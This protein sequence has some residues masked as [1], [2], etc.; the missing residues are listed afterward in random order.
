MKHETDSK[1][2]KNRWVIFPYQVPHYKYGNSSA[3]LHN[4]FHYI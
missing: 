4:E 3:K 1:E 2:A